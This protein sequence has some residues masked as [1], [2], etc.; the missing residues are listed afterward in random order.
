MT[1][2]LRPA[3]D[4]VQPLAWM[5]SGGT[6]PLRDPIVQALEREVAH[7]KTALEN[8]KAETKRTADESFAR[9]RKEAEAGFVRDEAKRLA[10]LEAAVARA[11]A[12]AE[13]QIAELDALALLLCET[14]LENAFA[15]APDF[16]DL[17]VRALERQLAPLRRET[18]LGVSVSA[19]DFADPA[20]LQALQE[21]LQTG[22]CIDLDTT[23]PA[24]EC[25]IE[26]RLGH[27]ELSLPRYWQALK[28]KLRSLAATE[29]S[30]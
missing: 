16:T 10:V 24:G 9:G 7:L 14:A 12:H 29:Q 2:L 1:S 3:S 13:R 18:V 15:R 28:A 20:A 8:A 6:T 5:A 4:T 22:F 26:L 25:R 23:L 19:A 17:I 21:R 11:S 27:I 30:P